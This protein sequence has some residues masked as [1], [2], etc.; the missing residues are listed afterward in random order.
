M[1]EEMQQEQEE[2][3]EIPLDEPE[4]PAQEPEPRANEPDEPEE[5]AQ[6]P[7]EPAET[8]AEKRHRFAAARRA[9][10]D[11]EREAAH[12]AEIDAIYR[13]AYEGQVN[14]YT[15]QPI[16]GRKDYEAYQRAYQE[17][18]ARQQRQKL[19]EG[20]MDPAALEN[21]IQQ[22]VASNPVVQQANQVVAR[23]QAMEQQAMA[24]QRD[25]LLRQGLQEIAAEDPRIKTSE[26]LQ[27][28]YPAGWQDML[29]YMRAGVP[30][31][32]AWRAANMETL[33]Q[34]R[35]AAGRQAAMND[36]GTKSHLRTMHGGGADTVS[37]PRA[38]LE[39]YRAINPGHTDAEYA[40]HWAKNHKK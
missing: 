16:M 39:M 12:Q 8:E 22:A 1:E 27:K 32:K 37:M 14:P 6:E 10:E 4:E 24:T 34:Q 36:M 35:S 17:D 26:D 7:E 13:R 30:L 3:V 40:R 33:M 19:Q 11:A 9:R 5:P 2:L 18:A 15:G 38:V 28:Y 20:G 21:M 31:A 29:Q 25:N 23:A